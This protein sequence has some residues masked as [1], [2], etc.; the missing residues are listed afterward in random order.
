MIPQHIKNHAADTEIS[1]LIPQHLSALETVAAS[2]RLAAEMAKPH[3][4]NRHHFLEAIP[5]YVASLPDDKSQALVVVRRDAG[6][7]LNI[8]G[9]AAEAVELAEA[10]SEVEAAQARVM[11][12]QAR[13]GRKLATIQR[14]ES[15]LTETQRR[16][17]P[18][19]FDFDSAIAAQESAIIEHYGIN[20]CGGAFDRI[21]QA[22][23]LKRLAPVAIAEING[24]LAEIEAE[25]AGLRG[26]PAEPAPEPARPF[27]GRAAKVEEQPDLAMEEPAFG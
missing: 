12:A 16:L 8:A 24:R 15:E 4:A 7:V 22:E 1:A 21:A 5:Q 19:Q 14:L 27:R 2:S 10:E 23:I 20:P 3:E 9:L 26:A 17:E 25:L 11:D 18:W 13:Q 6:S